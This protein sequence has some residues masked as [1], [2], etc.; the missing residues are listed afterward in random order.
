MRCLRKKKNKK[1]IY[2]GIMLYEKRE[3]KGIITYSNGAKY[4]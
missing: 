4:E 3:I 1:G 2:E